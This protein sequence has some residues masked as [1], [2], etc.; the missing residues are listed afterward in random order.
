MEKKWDTPVPLTS[1]EKA[2]VKALAQ[3]LKCPVIIAEL[4]FRKGYRNTDEVS[5]FFNPKLE[6]LH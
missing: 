1:E 5:S 4:L 6:S 2:Q 3:E